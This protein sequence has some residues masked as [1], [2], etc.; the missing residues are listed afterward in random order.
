VSN[1]IV[2]ADPI[3]ITDF[4]PGVGGDILHISDLLSNGSTNYDGSNPFSSGHLILEQN[5]DDTLVRF[6]ADGSTGADE[7]AIVVARLEN[8]TA[9]EILASNLNPSFAPSWEEGPDNYPP[10][11][12]DDSVTVLSGV[13]TDIDVLRNDTDFDND[14]L[15]VTNIT[16]PAH[17]SASI[18]FPGNLVCYEA[19]QGYSGP[20][21]FSYT[22]SDGN[23]GSD[24]ATVNVIVDDYS[25]TIDTTGAIALNQPET[26]GIE[27]SG[28][29]D[30]YAVSLKVGKTYLID[31]EGTDTAAGTLVNPYLRGI[32]DAG[33]SMISGTTDKES[34]TGK[35]SHLEYSPDSSG[36]YYIAA[37]AYSNTGTYTLTVSVSGNVA[38][39]IISPDGG[40]NT[41]V[42]IL[43]NSTTVTTVQATD[44][45]NDTLLFSITGGDDQQRFVIDSNSGALAFASAP[46]YENPTDLNGDN[47]YEVQV[48]VDDGNGERDGQTINVVVANVNETPPP[49]PD[50]VVPDPVV[51]DP[52]VP[53]PVVPDP[54]VP[55]PVVPDPVVPDPVDPDPVDPDPVDP[56]PVDPDPVDPD[57]VDDDLFS[58]DD[59][60]TSDDNIDLGLNPT[61]AF[62]NTIIDG[63]TATTGTTTDRDTGETVN[64]TSINPAGDI[65]REDEGGDAGTVDFEVNSSISVSLSD[66]QGL[67]VTERTG[68]SQGSLTTLLDRN[69]TSDPSEQQSFLDQLYSQGGTADIVELTPIFPQGSEGEGQLNIV[70]GESETPQ[71]IIIDLQYWQGDTPPEINISGSGY[72]VIRGAG[73]F[74]GTE[75]SLA[76]FSADVDVVLGSD[77]AQVFFFGPDDDVI[78]GAGGDDI[79][80]S[81]GGMDELHGDAGNDVVIG[82]WDADT[83]YG[84]EGS[85]ILQGGLSDA[86]IWQFS[87]DNEQG[88]H[89]QFSPSLSV[90][91]ETAGELDV[92]L[93]EGQSWDGDSR[94]A[95]TGIDHEIIET[96][97]QLYHAVTGELPS[98]DELNLFSNSGLTYQALA[99][100]AFSAYQGLIPVE[101]QEVASQVEMLFSQVWGAGVAT[102]EDT[103]I[104]VDYILAGGSWSEGLLVLAQHENH[105]QQ[106][107]NSQGELLL[108][109]DYI[110]GESGWSE[111][112]SD[113]RLFG[114]AG[115]DILVGGHGSD[116]LD[117]GEGHDTA[118]QLFDLSQYQFRIS[119]SGQ[120]LLDTPSLDLG[121]DTLVSIEEIQFGDQTI[122]SQSS[123]MENDDLLTAAALHSLVNG[124]SPTLTDMNMYSEINSDLDDLTLHMLSEGSNA[125]FWEG[126]NSFE[127]VQELTERVLGVPIQGEDLNYWAGQI[128]NGSIDRAEGFVLCLGVQ[129]Y[130]TSLFAD[131]GMILG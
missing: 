39:E 65:E 121:T 104:G 54:V 75:E 111:D 42:N 117:G 27:Q 69:P 79:V 64:V 115:N 123:N 114:G 63:A 34:G 127:F 109:E 53:D 10:T 32:Y 24:T 47:S 100:I 130:Q 3:L 108:T 2:T 91:P 110:L 55:D 76:G 128:E 131:G 68:S 122:A 125:S 99:E 106:I 48:A 31:L 45:N 1:V 77:D 72:V 98:L 35:N 81:S 30:W 107:E 67:I 28:D 126:L 56:D 29:E 40:N 8:V 71:V 17:G 58:G 74:Q 80:A 59:Q 97:S 120:L 37:G 61:T 103:Q 124:S 15:S 14:S 116:F 95:F 12:A 83:L 22:A 87:S 66:N 33:G 82:G 101:V 7:T 6:D 38:P 112:L 18:V 89:L 23:G 36:N 57:P 50:P 16:D 94:F 85:D 49:V 84:G 102:S 90:L 46:D 9:S 93:I 11:I 4:T 52:V 62:S 20:D 21:T 60:S 43:E 70:M 118:V 129:E 96:V 119:E 19:I 41:V 73:I 51:P 44:T 78:H 5:G 105:V 86:G 88:L 13:A 25:N 113:D 92:W 26:G